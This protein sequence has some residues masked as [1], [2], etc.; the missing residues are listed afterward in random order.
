MTA[1]SLS[2]SILEPRFI[3]WVAIHILHHTC[4][5]ERAEAH[6]SQHPFTRWSHCSILYH[7]E[8]IGTS[9]RR[10]K[11]RTISVGPI[12][13]LPSVQMGSM[14]NDTLTIG[15]RKLFDD[16]TSRRCFRAFSIANIEFKVAIRHNIEIKL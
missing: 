4:S 5:P 12:C 11:V 15:K 13:P 2:R 7:I 16:K 1:V 6:N 10:T 9:I 3:T 14:D 8:L